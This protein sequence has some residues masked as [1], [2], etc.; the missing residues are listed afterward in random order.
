[1]QSAR[2]NLA[3]AEAGGTASQRAQNQSS[4]DSARL[5][6]RSAQ[7]T[8]SDD[9]ATLAAAR[10]QL[11]A[12]ERLDCIAPSSGSSSSAAATSATSAATGGSTGPTPSGGSSTTRTTQAVAAVTAPTVVT[13]S[14][15]ATMPT[16]ATLTGTVTPGGATTSYWFQYGTSAGYGR[17]TAAATVSGTSAVTVSRVV[18]G[19]KED[20]TYVY[21]LVA[22]NSHGT[23]YGTALTFT[24]AA[25]ACSA[26]RAAV[27]AAE[28]AVAAQRLTV[29]QQEQS[30]A[31]A[32]SAIDSAVDPATVQQSRV[33]VQQDMIAVANALKALRATTLRAPISGTVTAVNGAVGDTVGASS[34]S[35]S[36]ASSS[37]GTSA[38]A[39]RRRLDRRQRSSSS[40]SSPVVLARD[41]R[42]HEEAPGRRR[43]PGGG[44]GQDQGRPDRLGHALRAVERRGGGQGDRRRADVDGR[45]QRRHLRRH[46]LAAEPA[47]DREDRDDGGR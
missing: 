4:L 27:A 23:R 33:Q 39:G 24:T 19:L 26:D 30:V 2:S 5:Q 11:A 31:A 44:R 12:D 18:T 42:E 8:L 38:S 6:L 29:Q 36:S 40:P 28:R 14:A 15:S 16:T 13:G 45:L 3:N 1:M 25:T 46:D 22:R 37:S 10:A 34:A 9:Q 47:G 21:R 32:Q 20:T 17:R 7:Q 35:N 43:I 41:D